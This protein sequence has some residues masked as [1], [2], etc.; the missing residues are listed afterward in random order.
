[1]QKQIQRMCLSWKGHL[2]LAC[3][4]SI[5]FIIQILHFS[6]V[7]GKGVVGG[8]YPE[9]LWRKWF[10]NL[11]FGADRNQGAA[12][13][14]TLV[15]TV[16]D[17]FLRTLLRLTNG[18]PA[19]MFRAK[20]DLPSTRGTASC[21]WFWMKYP[22]TSRKLFMQENIL[23]KLDSETWPQLLDCFTEF[24]TMM[25]TCF[26]LDSDFC[27]YTNVLSYTCLPFYYLLHKLFD[28]FKL[29]VLSGVPIDL[30]NLFDVGYWL[31]WL[32]STL[33]K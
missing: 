11:W 19:E 21:F 9:D 31:Y 23:N 2:S 16:Q 15:E 26:N 10:S 27:Y 6:Q 3:M 30:L 32:P 13:I 29:V 25:T 14:F 12:Q 22:N 7:K 4:I 17:M 24:Y 20:T 33:R 5:R 18:M 8:F 28:C 1:M